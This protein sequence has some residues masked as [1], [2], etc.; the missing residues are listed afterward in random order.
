MG[1][2][3][4]RDTQC[5]KNKIFA[6]VD[7]NNFFV[8]CE[9]VFAP[10]L[11]KKPVVVLSNN[12]GCAVAR[13]NEAKALGVEMGSPYFKWQNLARKHGIKV[14]SSN[15]VLYG[16]MSHRVMRTLD[17]ISPRMESYSIDEAFL[18]IDG[19][20]DNER[21][22]EYGRFVRDTVERD[23]GMPVSVGI[24][25]T[26]T[27]AKIANH[28]VKRDPHLNGM[29]N[30]CGRDIDG[31]LKEIDVESIW[32]IGKMRAA[33]LKRNGYSTAL[34]L[35]NA[36]DRWVKKKLTVCGLRTV[37][38][39]R[40]ISCIPLEE[41]YGRKQSIVVS[42]SFGKEIGS[43]DGL[44]Q[45]VSTYVSK[46]AEKLRS[47]RSQ[48]QYLQIF[49][50]SDRFN[51]ER[52]YS[53]SAGIRLDPPTSDTATMLRWADLL[54][55]HIYNDAFAY[56]RAGVMLSDLVDASHFQYDNTVDVDLHYKRESLMAD[57]DLY[58]KKNNFGKI[59]FA[60]EGTGNK[61][62]SRQTLRSARFTT[63]WDELLTIQ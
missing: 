63:K 50:N 20:D 27:L 55:K 10:N 19:F 4:E 28:I 36:E 42:R 33:M 56:K 26:K 57:I 54:L 34:D 52:Y 12:D 24:A 49:I 7:C 61:I 38:E 29:I 23:T 15:Y 47:Q 53:N 21:L 1:R 62:H 2:C 45:A 39:L 35:K 58:N 14:F 60:Q 40:G 41:V 32:G 48:A 22:N 13:S 5:M 3:Y 11:R 59:R 46:A 30:L 18:E 8:S 44:C 16:D 51:K 9:R 6:L 25:P 37:W 43:Y 31:Y 17:N